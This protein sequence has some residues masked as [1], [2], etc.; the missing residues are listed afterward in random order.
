[1]N[2]W[3][4]H[5]K[6]P[7]AGL[8]PSN[9]L[10][11]WLHFNSSVLFWFQKSLPGLNANRREQTSLKACYISARVW[12]SATMDKSIWTLLLLLSLLSI[13]TV[14]VYGEG[15]LLAPIELAPIPCNDKAV[16]KLSRLAVTYINEDRADGYKF[17]LN[18]VANV[19]LHAQVSTETN[20]CSDKLPKVVVRYCQCEI[21][22][23]VTRDLGCKGYFLS[24]SFCYVYPNTPL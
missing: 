7:W 12:T 8:L 4:I 11:P 6:I 9:K 20:G 23:C 2:H 3:N 1:M 14:P 16:E 21:C 13:Q 10:C 22:S 17:A 19:H 18:R 15:L 5:S 24:R